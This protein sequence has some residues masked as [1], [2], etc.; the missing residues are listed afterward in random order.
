[1]R[2]TL[3]VLFAAAIILTACSTFNASVITITSVV[4]SAMK[5]WASLSVAGKTSAAIDAKVVVA[6]ER[7]RQSCAVVQAALVEY[8]QS[9]NNA[10]YIAALSAARAAADGL[11]DLITPLL[12]DTKATALKT[13]L[14]KA[15][16]L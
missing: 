11:I 7:Y 1:M 14:S 8:K 6:H 13:K 4:D 15:N 12:I 10:G 2:K 9:G 5:E 3:P 16:A